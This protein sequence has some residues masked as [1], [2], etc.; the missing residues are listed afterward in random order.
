M[1]DRNINPFSNRNDDG[2]GRSGQDWDEVDRPSKWEYG[3]E[4]DDEGSKMVTKS[5]RLLTNSFAVGKIYI[6]VIDEIDGE[7]KEFKRAVSMPKDGNN[8][9]VP[10]ILKMLGEADLRCRREVARDPSKVQSEFRLTQT[11][12]YLAF[13]RESEE[14]KVSLCEYGIQLKK[15]IARVSKDLHPTKTLDIKGEKVKVM[16]NGPIYLYDSFLTKKQERGKS[17]RTG[18]KYEVAADPDNNYR[19]KIPVSV[20]EDG[21][22]PSFKW[23]PGVYTEAEWEVIGKFLEENKIN[24]FD[25]YL[26]QLHQE[27][28]ID[29]TQVRDMLLQKF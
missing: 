11:F 25:D 13:L 2:F 24:L 20:L 4:T 16:M 6:P 19:S 27:S 28:C 3:N 7:E 29:E 9:V 8:F 17:K 14:L 12:Y 5:R 26:E 21:F 23:V 22:P 10:E 18:T 1:S 15:G